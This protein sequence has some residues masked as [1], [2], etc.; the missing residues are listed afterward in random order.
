M[1]RIQTENFYKS[2]EVAPQAARDFFTAIINH[3]EI[4]ND[5]QVHHTDTN[6]G[7]LR[8]AIP[9]HVLDAKYLRN[10][11]T[12]YW[13]NRKQVVF[14]RTFLSLWELKEFGFYTGTIPDWHKEPLRSD[15]RLTEHQWHDGAA[16]FINVL[17]AAKTKMLNRLVPH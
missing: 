1:P 10:F 8:L 17:G 3:F 7:D 11:A 14:T 15:I 2:I 5:V 9:A 4:K 12:L 6:G 16:G 13:Q